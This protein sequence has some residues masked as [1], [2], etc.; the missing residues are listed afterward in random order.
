MLVLSSQIDGAKGFE[1]TKFNDMPFTIS[2]RSER[3]IYDLRLLPGCVCLTAGSAQQ[4]Q[5]SR[6]D[7]EREANVED[8]ASLAN[9]SVRVVTEKDVAFDKSKQL[10]TQLHT[11]ALQIAAQLLERAV[12]ISESA[13]EEMWEWEVSA[14]YSPLIYQSRGM[15]ITLTL[16]YARQAVEADWLIA[17]S[18]TKALSRFSLT[19]SEMIK[20]T[21]MGT[22][23]ALRYDELYHY[24]SAS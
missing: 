6:Q 4:L 11:T 19:R 1:W 21:N 15:Y 8:R 16:R 10:Q 2:L 12:V 9:E 14:Y 23:S 7:F 24:L 3:L 13:V 18:F 17:F 20:L 5:R 22:Q